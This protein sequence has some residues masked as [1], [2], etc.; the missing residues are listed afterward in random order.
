MPHI[1][2][3][4]AHKKK[5]ARTRDPNPKNK[6]A[7]VKEG[8]SSLYTV[9]SPEISSLIS[10]IKRGFPIDTFERLKEEF[11]VN[12]EKLADVASIS[13]A[14]LHRRKVGMRRL[15]PDESENIYRLE[16]LYKIAVEVLGNKNSVKLWFSTPQM[17]FEGKTPLEYADT[18]PGA[19]EVER[20]LR[21]IEHGVL[22]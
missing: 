2:S 18:L 7:G 14:T 9:G 22:L 19:E 16:K 15:T 8:Q 6:I 3:V 17:V 5:V 1:M 11:G 20:V 21:R 13:L 10:Q 4:G 12:Q